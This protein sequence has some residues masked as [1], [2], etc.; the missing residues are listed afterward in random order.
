MHVV[1]SKGTAVSTT[2]TLNDALEPGAN[3]GLG[4]FTFVP[5]KGETYS[6]KIDEPAGVKAEGTFPVISTD[7][8]A[9]SVP[10]GVTGNGE[11]IH[12]ELNVTDKS[13]TMLIGAYCRG[14]LLDHKEVMVEPGK[15]ATVDLNP[16][17]SVG[18]VVRI[19][20][21][22][23]RAAEGS[24]Q[25]FDP[26]AER[27]VYRR[28]MQQ[29]HLA[30]APDKT[31]YAPAGKVNLTVSATDEKGQP[32]RA[33]LNLSVV[34]QSILTMADEKTARKLPTHFALIGEVRNPEDLEH[35]DF[36][37]NESN[38][39]SAL[40]LDLLLAVQGWR[41]FAEQNTEKFR[42]QYHQEAERILVMTGQSNR[43]MPQY[44]TGAI[45]RNRRRIHAAIQ[46]SDR[47]FARRE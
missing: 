14:R 31:R 27:L 8:V 4:V 40:A 2:E 45:Q 11:A 39:K 24:R 15:T 3:Q 30:I 43:D 20:A 25:V 22:E 41:R 29:L 16:A 13:R 38:S 47:P 44:P 26:R 21:F 18:G 33:I 36:L 28:G 5:Q 7:K 19:T 12:V 23:K 46:R 32:A 1:D 17:E 10:T 6:L 42:D 34:N 35:A 9:M 37:F